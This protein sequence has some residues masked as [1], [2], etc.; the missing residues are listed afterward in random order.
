MSSLLFV[1]ALDVHR[2]FGELRLQGVRITDGNTGAKL[3][4]EASEFFNEPSLEEAA[5]CFIALLGAVDGQG[6]TQD[7]L[8]QAVTEKMAIN[9]KRRWVQQPDGTYRHAEGT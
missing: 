8:A 5:D 3:K 4:E 1:A 7:Q 9:R 2:W 6:W